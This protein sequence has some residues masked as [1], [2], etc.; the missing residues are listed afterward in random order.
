MNE[1]PMPDNAR[2][3]P[4][5]QAQVLTCRCEEVRATEIVAAL[6]AGARTVDDVKR[7]TRA[8]MGICQ[9]IFC[10]PTIAAMVSTVTG[11]PIDQVAPMTA[12]PPTRPVALEVLAAMANDTADGN[13]S[14]ARDEG[15]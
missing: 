12:R 4:Q 5:D 3:E 8:G 7:R 11:T 15:D 1:S 13:E 6:V 9:G 14:A 2:S 10:S